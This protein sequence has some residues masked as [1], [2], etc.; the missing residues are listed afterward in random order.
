MEETPAAA[1]ETE[2]KEPAAQEEETPA[3]QTAQ[4]TSQELLHGRNALRPPILRRLA[5]SLTTLQR[6]ACLSGSGLFFA[7]CLQA[8]S[9]SAPRTAANTDTVRMNTTRPTNYAPRFG[10]D[11]VDPAPA[12]SVQRGTEEYRSFRE[13][14]RNF[15]GF[16]ENRSIYG[17]R[18]WS[19]QQRSSFQEGGY[20]A[21]SYGPMLPRAMVPA[22]PI[23]P[24][25]RTP[26]TITRSWNLQPRSAEMLAAGECGDGQGILEIHRTDTVSCARKTSC[27]PARI[28]MCPWPRSAA[29]PAHRRSGGGKNAPP[30]G[31]G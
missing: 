2:A 16:Q 15:G 25:G 19:E 23:H 9:A 14:P 21:S 12:P 30:A 20:V 6:Q 8:R 7:S 3:V 24:G 17:E 26:A 13:Q 4:Q 10:P 31:R 29:L 18:S 5:Q 28:F 11:A 27:R 1:P 22:L